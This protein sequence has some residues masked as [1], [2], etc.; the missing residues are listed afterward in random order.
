MPYMHR[1]MSAHRPLSSPPA[2]CT[3]AAV[4]LVFSLRFEGERGKAIT[5]PCNGPSLPPV[6]H[7]ETGYKIDTDWLTIAISNTAIVLNYS[8]LRM[9]KGAQPQHGPPPMPTA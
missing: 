7:S 8:S 1:L 5:K 6:D 9:S 2:P 3:A 4:M